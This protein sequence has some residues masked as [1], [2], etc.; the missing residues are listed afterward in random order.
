M[1][2]TT[3]KLTHGEAR[4]EQLTIRT[5]SFVIEI[6]G[7][8]YGGELVDNSEIMLGPFG[9]NWT[10]EWEVEPDVMDQDELEEIEAFVADKILY[11]IEKGERH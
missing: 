10:V 5:Y 4:E 2:L 6:E 7:E 11:K 3:A 8:E 1:D 9:E